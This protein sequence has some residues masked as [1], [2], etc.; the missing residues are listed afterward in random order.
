V[1]HAEH[2]LSG[3]IR[4]AIAQGHLPRR[5]VNPVT[6]A[7]GPT[8]PDFDGLAYSRE[9]PGD[10]KPYTRQPTIEAIA[11]MMKLSDMFARLSESLGK[12]WTNVR[13]SEEGRLYR[14]D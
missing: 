5:T 12:K 7:E 10:S 2:L 8:I 13:L 14:W 9:G 11:A 3:I 1:A 6:Y 4:F